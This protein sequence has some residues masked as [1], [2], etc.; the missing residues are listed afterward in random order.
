MALFFLWSAF[1]KYFNAIVWFPS[2]RRELNAFHLLCPNCS[3]ISGCSPISRLNVF[4]LTTDLFSKYEYRSSLSLH[5]SLQRLNRDLS[6]S[7]CAALR[8]S[9]GVLRNVTGFLV[10]RGDAT[11]CL[12]FL[13]CGGVLILKWIIFGKIFPLN[14][15]HA[16]NK[17]EGGDDCVFAPFLLL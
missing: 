7:S 1:A 13:L 5:T 8:H 14:W 4:S 17:G 10:L 11:C 9:Y 2:L 16:S 15:L 3:K 12:T 6:P